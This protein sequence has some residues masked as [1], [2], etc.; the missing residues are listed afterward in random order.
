M[1]LRMVPVAQLFAKGPRVV[2]DLAHV[3]GKQA[4]VVMEGED[5]E[6]DKRLIEQLEDPLLHLL[7]NA[8]DHGIETVEDRVAAGKPTSGTVTLSAR[9]EGGHVVIEIADDGA[10]LDIEKIE[11]TA[12]ACGLEVRADDPARLAEALMSPGFTTA[13]RV[14]DVSG[15]GV[16]LDVVRRRV[17][18]LGGTVE[19]ESERGRGTTF[20]LSVPLTLAIMPA[21][22]VRVGAALR[23]GVARDGRFDRLAAGFGA[24]PARVVHRHAA[25]DRQQPGDEPPTRIVPP[26]APEGPNERLLQ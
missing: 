1:R 14:T 20:R 18:D 2:R 3:L 13:E 5:T 23:V 17:L 9:Q 22:L 4:D 25:R 7:R 24:R 6:L 10:G 16:G 15:R 8:V 26:Q 21:L 11:R 12:A 19:V